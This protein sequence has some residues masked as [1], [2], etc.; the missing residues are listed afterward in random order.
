MAKAVFNKCFSQFNKFCLN[1]IIM[2]YHINAY[3]GK[4][5]PAKFPYVLV[6]IFGFCMDAEKSVPESTHGSD[7]LENLHPLLFPI[8]N[9]V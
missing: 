4:K 1:S 9:S 7:T 2:Y 8:S 5:N 6:R 3:L